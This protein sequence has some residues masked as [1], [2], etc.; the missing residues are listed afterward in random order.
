MKLGGAGGGRYL[1]RYL[2][3]YLYHYL[4]M[5]LDLCLYLSR[6]PIPLPLHRGVAVTHLLR[7]DTSQRCNATVPLAKT[8]ARIILFRSATKKLRR[9]A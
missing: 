2:Y 7:S 4:Y 9:E 5:Y 8:P 1:Y 3:L 6:D